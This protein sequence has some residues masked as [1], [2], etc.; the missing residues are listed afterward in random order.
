MGQI[1]QGNKEIIRQAGKKIFYDKGYRNGTLKE[2][3]YNANIPQGLLTYYFKTKDDLVSSIFNEF[4]TNIL[5]LIDSYPELNINN[6]L[7]KEI[8]LAHIYFSIILQDENNRRFYREI[9]EK[10][11]SNYSLLYEM[12]NEMF[13]GYIKDF[14]LSISKRDFHI[15]ELLHHAARRTFFYHYF[16]ENWEMTI[17][18]IVMFVEGIAPRLYRIDQD[19]V[20]K[21][22]FQAQNVVKEIDCSAIK[23]L[24]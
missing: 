4:Y 18:E 22:L 24:V 21:Y 14:N 3:A 13:Y 15:L 2:I 11:T 19:I 8:V 17:P 5:D 7:Y 12:S 16:E 1:N 9:R 6:S 10:R 23:F 20:D